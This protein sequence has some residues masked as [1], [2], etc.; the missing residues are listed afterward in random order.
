VLVGVLKPQSCL[1]L[2]MCPYLARTGSVQALICPIRCETACFGPVWSRARRHHG[3]IVCP[4]DVSRGIHHPLCVFY[5]W[6]RCRWC[7]NDG[8]FKY[9]SGLLSRRRPDLVPGAISRQ[10]Y[11]SNVP[12]SYGREKH[13]MSDKNRITVCW[14]SL[15][16]P[17]SIAASGRYREEA[18]REL[19]RTLLSDAELSSH[20]FQPFKVCSLRMDESI[21][22]ER[23]FDPITDRFV[24]PGLSLWASMRVGSTCC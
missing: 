21:V 15:F 14:E 20:V 18:P 24:V 22:G 10:N 9:G 1:A 19:L 3:R 12:S 16:C 5:T 11:L 4:R 7:L 23:V 6:L 2:K 13:T 17:R 8:R